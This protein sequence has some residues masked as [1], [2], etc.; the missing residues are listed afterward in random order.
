M[1]AQ[2]HHHI[3]CV[4]PKPSRRWSDANE[5]AIDCRR[6]CFRERAGH[7]GLRD[8]LAVS[9]IRKASRKSDR[10]RVLKAAPDTTVTLVEDPII[11]LRYIVVSGPNAAVAT[12]HIR[13]TI[14]LVSRDAILA[15]AN[16]A[17]GFDAESQ[18]GRRL[19]AVAGE[20]FDPHVFA[21]LD[22]KFFSNPDP[23]IRAD[24]IKCFSYAGWK[25]LRPLIERL[26]ASDSHPDVKAFARTALAAWD[27]E[28]VAKSPNS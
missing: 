23:R 5:R 22:R 26:A 25:E 21:L 10:L 4:V 28:S 12:G 18:A 19:L 11:G 13:R 17:A 2:C 14:K 16:D 15:Q 3:G 9:E 24:M 7:S 20:S 27:A 1:S 8:A 6:Q